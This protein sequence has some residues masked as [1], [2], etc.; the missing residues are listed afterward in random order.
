[1]SIRVKGAASSGASE[2]WVKGWASAAAKALGK[3]A[4]DIAIV[5]LPSAEIRK[6]NGTYRGKPAVTDVLSFPAHEMTAEREKDK[7]ADLGDIFIAPAAARKKASERG[8]EYRE[9]LKLLIVHSVLHLGGYDHA[10]EP[11]AAAMERM[12]D[13]IMKA[14]S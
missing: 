1:M 11:E 13:K 10:H 9:Y 12:E 3:P 5:F 14:K 7:L 4:S 2:R 8:M 6:L